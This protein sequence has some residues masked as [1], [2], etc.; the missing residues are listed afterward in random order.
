MNSQPEETAPVSVPAEPVVG[1]LACV[2]GCNFGACFSI[3]AGNNSIGRGKDNRIVIPGDPKISRSK[4]AFVV[5]DPEEREFFVRPSDGQG[6]VRLNGKCVLQPQPLSAQ[7][8]IAMGDS[9]FLF[10]PL[11]S[12]T[13]SWEDYMP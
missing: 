1:W 3:F 12:K 10:I 2:A 13:F 5:Y 8:T 4:H 9:K 7:D 6:L 11:C